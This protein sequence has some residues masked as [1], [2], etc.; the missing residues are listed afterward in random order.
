MHAPTTTLLGMRVLLE[1]GGRFP[2]GRGAVL[3]WLVVG[4][5]L[6]L[7]GLAV[8]VQAG[9]LQAALGTEQAERQLRGALEARL[10]AEGSDGLQAYVRVLV[11]RGTMGLRYLS[12]RVPGGTTVAEAGAYDDLSVPM[13]SP[14]YVERLRGMMLEQS[15]ERRRFDIRRDGREVARVEYI[16]AA[17]AVQA[18]RT[19]AVS[20]LQQQG[21]LQIVAG[22]FL[23]GVGVW[24]VM[25]PMP[26]PATSD[27]KERVRG[28]RVNAPRRSG[29]EPASLEGRAAQALDR[30]Q[31]GVIIVDADIRIRDINHVAEQLTGWSRDDAVGRLVYSVFHPLADDDQPLTTPAETAVRERCE[32]PAQECRL[33]ARDGSIHHVEMVA[34]VLENSA[35]QAEGAVLFFHDIGERRESV[36]R[37]RADARRTQ[38]IVDHLDEG[39]LTTDEAGVITFANAR[40]ARMFGYRRE[41]L[42]GATVTK[43]MPV[44]F[45]NMPDVRVSDYSDSQTRGRLPRVVGWRRDATTFPVDLQT[46]TLAATEDGDAPQQ[47]LVLRD[48]TQ[49]L[50]KDNL[51][52]RMGRLFDHAAEEIYVFDAQSLY[53]TEVN[54]AAQ[55][56][57]QME[58]GQLARMTPAMITEGIEAEALQDYYLRLRSGQ[59]EHVHYRARHRRADGS[60]YPV[61]VR[62]SYSRAEEPPVFMAMA[63]DCSERES[64]EARLARQAMQ[65]DLTGLANR[66]SAM[67]ALREHL[68][69]AVQRGEDLAVIFFDLD[70]FKRVNDRYGHETGDA[71]LREVAQRLDTIVREGH[72]AARLSGDE[73][74]VF[75]AG[76]SGR[77][78]VEAFS[79]RLRGLLNAPIVVG[80]QRVGITASLGVAVFRGAAQD[81]VEP[82]DILSQADRAMYLAKKAGRDRAHI[83]YGEEPAQGEQQ[84]KA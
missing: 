32:T 15:G 22:A 83:Y 57:L 44:P 55:R 16:A 67:N 69:S 48:L 27:L 79:D 64:A 82:G 29:P 18:V 1:R 45:L 10:S 68:R 2:V 75:F 3:A 25:R 24:I 78:Q 6:L 61:E 21:W 33:R 71:V 19:D 54:R 65:D 46:Q 72:F 52:L 60:G 17:G 20:Q 30:L 40:A 8:L 66:P 47:V 53:F 26:P 42:V 36:E 80:E 56:N 7:W 81:P 5:V 50:R 73:F 77:D 38:D 84:R 34:A 74:V 12:I 39:V 13:I 59:T 49:Q 9:R 31:R 35:G 58:D 70:H 41:E 63:T 76:S 51:S 28:E 23:L 43:L 14:V 62:L 11:N 37:L 4:L